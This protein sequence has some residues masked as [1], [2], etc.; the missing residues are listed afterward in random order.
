MRQRHLIGLGLAAASLLLAAGPAAGSHRPVAAFNIVLE[1]SVETPPGDPD[2]VGKA[3]ILLLPHLGRVC[4]HLRVA[5]IAPV[6][7]AH[8]HEA[9]AGEPGDAIV[10]LLPTG[11]SGRSSG[12]VN[13]PAARI[14][15][16]MDNPAGYYV[17]V[18]N[19]DFPFGALRGQLA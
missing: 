14:N 9:P 10:P 5:G 12:C 3:H 2:G 19:A 4:Y 6:L 15:E 18:H 11:Q 7:A 17:N 13:F 1:G 8:I 16:I